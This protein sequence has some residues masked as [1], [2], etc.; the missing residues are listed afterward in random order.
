MNCKD[1]EQH[2]ALYPYDELT[3][4]ER[5]TCDEHLA[6]CAACRANLDHIQGLNLLLNKRPSSEPTPEMLAQCRLALED[7]ID[8]QLTVVTWKRLLADGWAPLKALSPSQVGFALAI[9]AFG[10]SLGWRLRPGVGKQTPA[11]SATQG[12][13][14]AP[15]VGADLGNLRINAILQVAPS[16]QTGQIRITVDAERRMTLEGS[17]EDPHIRQML[18]EAL[19]SYSNPGIRRESLDALETGSG[20]PSVREALLYTIEHDP[21]P[22]MRLKALQ[23]VRKMEW[24]PEIRQALLAALKPGN[25]PGVRVAALKVLVDRADPSSLPALERLA[26]ND[27]D[28]YV[29][30]QCLSAARRLGGG[31]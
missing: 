21:N 28:R 22:G 9:L 30:L 16:P 25:N 2:L 26:A 17:L 8:R 18:V 27:P 19:K 3:P 10:F 15:F 29:R 31:F 23:T 1:L 7:A 24:A 20:E 4:D 5:R 13:P 11:P 12:A 14:A 6:A